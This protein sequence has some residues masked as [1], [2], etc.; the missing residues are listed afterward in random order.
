MCASKQQFR[1]GSV[2][3]P[4][5]GLNKPC[6]KREVVQAVILILIL[7]LT[8]VSSQGSAWYSCSQHLVVSN[9]LIYFNATVQN[10]VLTAH[11]CPAI[12]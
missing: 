2:P 1:R 10:G 7:T 9:D 5:E 11:C 8:A 4:K 3:T 12:S 6:T